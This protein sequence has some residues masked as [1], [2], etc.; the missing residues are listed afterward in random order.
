MLHNLKDIHAHI[1]S[2]LYCNHSGKNTALPYFQNLD[3]ADY[4]TIKS[5]VIEHGFAIVNFKGKSLLSIIKLLQKLFG[6][7][8]K[9]VGIKKKYIAKV[10]PS[11]NGKYYVNSIFAQP[12]HTDEGYRN[13]FPRFVSLYCVTPSQTGG[14]STI[15]RTKEVLDQLHSLFDIDVNNFFQSSFLQIESAYETINKQILFELN[16][17]VIGMSY[18]PILR[19]I[20]TS[21]LGY[22]MIACINQFIHDPSNQYRIKLNANDLLIMDNCQVF[23][24]RTAFGESDSRLMLRLW[25]EPLTI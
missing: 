13:E 20:T 22:K 16:E 9:D 3:I 10:A 7:A 6:R 25:N 11:V 5:T 17:N 2:E 15:V 14:V 21:E 12:L 18:S 19:S 23:H 8:V 1:K 24:G 4:N